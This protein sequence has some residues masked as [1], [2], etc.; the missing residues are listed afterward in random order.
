MKMKMVIQ[1]PINNEIATVYKSVNDN[2]KKDKYFQGSNLDKADKNIKLKPPVPFK[3]CEF[4]FKNSSYVA[5]CCRIKASDIIYNDITLTTDDPNVEDRKLEI[6][7]NIL[8]EN[9]DEVYNAL[10]DYGYAGLGVVEYAYGVH[11]FSLKQIPVNTCDIIRVTFEGNEYYLLQQKI[12]STT[13][14]FRIMGEI[15]PPNFSHYNNQVLGYCSLIGGDNFYE[16]FATP[17]W[18]QERKK[19]FTEI[20]ISD[21]NYNTISNGNIATGVLNINLEP[22]LK[23]PVTLDENGNPVESKSREQVIAD[24]LTDNTNGIAVVFT[25]SSRPVTFDFTKLENDNYGYLESQEEKA[26][27]AVLNCYNIPLARMMINT[28]KESMNSNKT[29]SIWEIY[30]IELRNDQNHLAKPFIRELIYDLYNIQV[31]VDMSLPIFS[32]RREIEI[33]NILSQWEKGILN[34]QQTI[35]ALSEYTK[36]IDLKDYDFTVNRELW[37]YRQIDGY[38]ELLNE[39]DMLKLEAVEDDISKVV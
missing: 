12:Q 6:I 8:L 34:L 20:A 14:Y 31:N 5:K 3:D 27:Q 19:I 26:E 37:E 7:Q 33:N 35:T 21:K 32:D 23:K 11:R 10:V 28:E 25:E 22:Q 16:F 24:E 1:N 29:Q 4:V 17:V 9:I 15:Y 30:T 39:V 36:V 38:Y 2:L 18:V 13:N